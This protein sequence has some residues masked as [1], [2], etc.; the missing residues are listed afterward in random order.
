MNESLIS[1]Y[2]N[3]R[4]KPGPKQLK[5]IEN[6]IHRFASDLCAISF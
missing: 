3:G 4:K 1:Q 2:A 6:A 5:K